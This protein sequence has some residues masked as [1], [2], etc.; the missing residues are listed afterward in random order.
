VIY[1]YLYLSTLFNFSGLLTIYYVSCF[2]LIIMNRS[3]LI[4]RLAKLHPQLQIEDAELGVK[5]IIDAFYHALSN[6][7]RV[8]IRG[9]GSFA[10]K[11]RPPRTGRNPITGT[12]VKVSA[13]Y[14]PD[15]KVGKVLRERLRNTSNN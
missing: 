9:F 3:D 1:I 12:R 15:F 11:Y 5:V 4:V 6:G 7:G 13:K 8:E 14:V 2:G 10:L